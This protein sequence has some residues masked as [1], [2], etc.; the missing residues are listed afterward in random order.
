MGEPAGTWL[1]L[2]LLGA[3]VAA[4]GT[5]AGQFM[6]SRPVVAATLAGWIAGAP[7]AGAT[8]G[9]LL[10][11]LHLGV[12][13]VGAAR[14]PEG[15]PP[16]VAAGGVYALSGGGAGTLL[17]AL[18]FFLV[19]ES[20]S[21]WSV[22]ALRRINGR[23]L[24]VKTTGATTE[25]ALERRHLAAL[26]LDLLR[27]AVLVLTGSAL[28][29]LILELVDRLA[30]PGELLAGRVLALVVVALLAGSVHLFGSRVRLVAAGAATGLLLAILLRG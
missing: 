18:V 19:W 25:R 22:R 14:Y 26:G 2:A 23:L 6:V 16:A 7:L 9:I 5:G 8:A 30:P 12:L 3:W 28:L 24:Q 20:V 21:G 11:A 15:G 29:L 1:L 27:G 17:T 13:P 10:E 4:D